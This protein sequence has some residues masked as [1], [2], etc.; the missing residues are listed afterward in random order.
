MTRRIGLSLLVALALVLPTASSAAAVSPVVANWSA[1]LGAGGYNGY[2]TLVAN[3][4]GTGTVR[5][6]AK[7]LSG[8]ASYSVDVRVGS[9]R[10]T[11]IAT[12]ATTV[13][14]RTGTITRSFGLTTTQAAAAVRH[15]KTRLITRCSS[16]ITSVAFMALFLSFVSRG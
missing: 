8:R 15:G 16:R 14:S 12:L 5:I 4:R 11:R 3:A 1:A 9:C 13:S 10:G 7:R 6:V 2:A